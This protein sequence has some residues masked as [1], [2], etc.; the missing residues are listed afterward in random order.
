MKM[1]KHEKKEK[2]GWEGV[3]DYSLHKTIWFF[4]IFKM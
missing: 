3:G 2:K 4:F 1:G